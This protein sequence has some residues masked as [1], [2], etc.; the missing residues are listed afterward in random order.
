MRLVRAM[1]QKPELSLRGL[2]AE[3]ND[4]GLAVNFAVWKIVH[5]GGLV[6]MPGAPA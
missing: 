4:R 6:R 5:R 2:L 1:E 3:L